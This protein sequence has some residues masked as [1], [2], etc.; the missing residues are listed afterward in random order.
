MPA[1]QVSGGDGSV[2]SRT[3]V[4]SLPAAGAAVLGT[5]GV[6]TDVFAGDTGIIRFRNS[7]FDTLDAT[8]RPGASVA[9]LPGGRL[10]VVCGGPTLVVDAATGAITMHDAHTQTGCAVAATSR[11]LVIAGGTDG[12]AVTGSVEVDDA[13]TLA[14]VAMLTLAVPRTGATAIALPN[15][16][17]LIIGGADATGAPIATLE[18]F[19]P[20]A[21]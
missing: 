18:L 8:A 9:A 12:G 6:A 2:I 19:T 7:A 21:P 17:V 4:A 14:P 1:A 3:E 10:A 20:D 16:Q 15:D 11:H 13:T 5:D